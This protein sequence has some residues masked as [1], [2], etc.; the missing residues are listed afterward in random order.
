MIVGVA[1]V[2]MQPTDGLTSASVSVSVSLSL[3]LSLLCVPPGARVVEAVLPLLLHK[4][5]SNHSL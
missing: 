1:V 5:M 2:V 4:G 3:S